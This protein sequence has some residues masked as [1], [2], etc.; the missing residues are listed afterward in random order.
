MDTSVNE[1]TPAGAGNERLIRGG[2]PLLNAM[3]S[4]RTAIALLVLITA[5]CVLGTL[6]PQGG[7]FIFYKKNFPRWQSV[8]YSLAL[9]DLYHSWWFLSLLFALS[10]NVAVCT[11]RRAVARIR[12]KRSETEPMGRDFIADLPVRV[13]AGC[14]DGGAGAMLEKL[15]CVMRSRGYDV[16]ARGEN[17]EGVFAIAG[18]YSFLGETILHVSIILILAGGMI[19][20]VFGFNAYIQGFPGETL[21]VPTKEYRALEA[22]AEQAMVKMR[23]GGDDR[24]VEISSLMREMKEF[25]SKVWFRVRIDDFKTEFYPA[26]PRSTSEAGV[27]NWFT[28]LTLMEEGRDAATKKISVND[29]MEYKGISI[30]QSSYGIDPARYRDF[31]VAASPRGSSS[32]VIFNLERIGYEVILP[33]GG[34]IVRAVKFEPDFKIDMDSGDVYSSSDNPENPALCI[35][36]REAG[37]KSGE[38]SPIWLFK[39]MP[40]F[41]RE[42]AR[43]AGLTHNFELRNFGAG[44]SEYTGLKIAYD[45]G[46]F[47]VW[48]GS[49]LMVL[50]LYLAFNTSC[51]RVWAVSDGNGSRITAGG[52]SSRDPMGFA[53]EFQSMVSECGIAPEGEKNVS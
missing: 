17:V 26:D 49:F 41:S 11:V 14:G 10:A 34:M 29:P 12:S 3:S 5:A 16:S 18:R 1:I 44:P 23:S 25:K 32:E 45:P 53:A 13:E 46:V 22:R 37:G 30:Y 33:G 4:I 47:L 7:D 31:S 21:S 24:H 35:S 6:V 43:A 39:N 38:A 42:R 28:T 15:V 9:D 52:V 20:S 48:A 40:E 19:G 36:V 8:I 51:R 27:K 2:N 50:G